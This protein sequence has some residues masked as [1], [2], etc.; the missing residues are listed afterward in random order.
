[1]TPWHRLGHELRYLMIILVFFGPVID[2][3]GA[4]EIAAACALLRLADNISADGAVKHVPGK[5]GEQLLI[6]AILSH[7]VD[8][9]SL[10]IKVDIIA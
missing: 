7:F 5:V 3:P 2:A 9:L 10:I 8:F 6:I 4:E 1:M